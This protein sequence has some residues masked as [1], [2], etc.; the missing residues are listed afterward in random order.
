MEK[1]KEALEK[2]RTHNLLEVRSEGN[3]RNVV[4]ELQSIRLQERPALHDL[5]LEPTPLDSAHLEKN[6]IFAY[7]KRNPFCGVYDRLRTH[8]L[9]RMTLNGWRSLAIISPSPGAGKSVVAIN[10][11]MSIAQLPN[12]RALLIDFDLRS[13]SVLS[14]I[15]IRPEHSLNDFLEDRCLFEETLIK[16]QLARLSVTGAAHRIDNST[17]HLASKKVQDVITSTKS[18]N[19]DGIVIFDLPPILRSDDTISILPSIDCALLVIPDGS[20]T[21]NEIDEC[22][23][24]IPDTNLIGTVLNMVKNEKEFAH[25]DY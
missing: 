8:V 4:S 10:L 5:E 25:Y 17:E 14:Y 2:T 15:G 9:H 19:N 22:L 16:P 18:N 1:I 11:A 24:Q 12:R 23:Q 20:Y 6:R 21:E 3:D 7:S 13:P